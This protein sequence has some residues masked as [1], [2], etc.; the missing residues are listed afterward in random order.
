MNLK[1]KSVKW[2][3]EGILEKPKTKSSFERKWKKLK[4]LVFPYLFTSISCV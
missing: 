4:E 3:Y 2:V 1:H